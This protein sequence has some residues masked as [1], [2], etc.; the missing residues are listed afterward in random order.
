MN[1]LYQHQ[2]DIYTLFRTKKNK[3]KFVFYCAPTSSGKTLTPL[4]LTNEY[5]VVFV[6]ASKHIGLSLAKS[7]FFLEKKIG[8]AFGCNDVDNI[9]LNYNAI[10]S[11]KEVKKRKVPDHSDGTKVELMICDILSFES[12]MLY[13]KA[14]NKIENLVLFWDEPT[15]GLDEENPYLHEIIKKNWTINK[16]PNIIFS[17]ATLPKREEINKI[18]EN[19]LAKYDNSCFEYIETS[20][21]YTNLCIYDANGNVIM[22]HNYFKDYNKMI[23]FI[24]YQSTKYYK[25][26]NCNECSKFLVFYDKHVEKGYINRN[27]FTITDINLNKIKDIY[28]QALKQINPL[29]WDSIQKQYFEEH[30]ILNEDKHN[31]GPK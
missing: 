25:F 26:Y 27:L 4:A 12:A 7:A 3:S 24:D 8:F 29:N 22:P 31:I 19:Q 23:E 11:Y 9:R 14:F 2:K 30:P 13:M 1:E 6:C 28:I 16:I 18:I 20:D 5:K 15:I 10:N 21:Q 17:C